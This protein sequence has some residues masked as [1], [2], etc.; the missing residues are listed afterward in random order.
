MREREKET[1]VSG[2]RERK[3]EHV[4][5]LVIVHVWQTYLSCIFDG[6]TLSEQEQ[7][8]RPDK[9]HSQVRDRSRDRETAK[10]CIHTHL[11][12]HAHTHTYVHVFVS[13]I[14]MNV[15]SAHT[16]IPKTGY[17]HTHTG[18][19]LVDSLWHRHPCHSNFTATGSNCT[20]L[21][22]REGL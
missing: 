13:V 5:Y 8:K 7:R 11:Y 6:R 15:S 9:R 12:P 19:P 20:A 17:K 1:H 14:H 16:Y 3:R 22:V 21:C 2:E 10:R 18:L 4:L